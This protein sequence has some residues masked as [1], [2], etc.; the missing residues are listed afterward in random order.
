MRYA[1]AFALSASLISAGC[2]PRLSLRITVPAEYQDQSAE[3][4][5]PPDG[6]T[7]RGQYREAYTAFWWNCTILKSSDTSARCPFMCSGTAAAAAGCQ[8]G[9]VDSENQ[10]AALEK[11]YGPARTREFLALRIAEDD[12]YSKIRSHFPYGPSREKR[13][14]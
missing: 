12:G 7:E 6:D 13:P 5:T 3:L 14:D 10:I 11:K 2:G 1:F 4:T 9:A 8:D